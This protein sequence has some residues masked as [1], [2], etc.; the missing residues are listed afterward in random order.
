MKKHEIILDKIELL[1]Q[2]V[3]NH[4]N[5]SGGDLLPEDFEVS[6]L[7]TKN[8]QKNNTT[9]AYLTNE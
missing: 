5:T 1:I 9:N 6:T 2:L 3:T 4:F 7:M 8:I